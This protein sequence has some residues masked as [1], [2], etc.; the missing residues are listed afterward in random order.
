MRIYNGYKYIK[1]LKGYIGKMK[2]S[3]KVS[4][5]SLSWE[6]QINHLSLYDLLEHQRS[7]PFCFNTSSV[8]MWGNRHINYDVFIQCSC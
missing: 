7:K 2:T 1:Y 3:K 5:L 8:S 6:R 4:E